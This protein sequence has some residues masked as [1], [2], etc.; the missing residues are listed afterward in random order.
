MKIKSFLKD[1]VNKLDW[2]DVGLIKWSCIFFGVL[3]VILFPSLL[4]LNI[5]LIVV[6]VVVLAIRPMRRAYF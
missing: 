2:L 6:I 4:E 5:W 3:L 1:K